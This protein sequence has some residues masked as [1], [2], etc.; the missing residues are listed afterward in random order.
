MQNPYKNLLL[1]TN[2]LF[3]NRFSKFLLYILGQKN[4]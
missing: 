3:V 2:F 4:Y 1:G